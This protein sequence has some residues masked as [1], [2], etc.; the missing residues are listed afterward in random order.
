MIHRWGEKKQELAKCMVQLPSRFLL[1]TCFREGMYNSFKQSFRFLSRG[2]SDVPL[3]KRK[4]PMNQ[5]TW[6]QFTHP[7]MEHSGS[8][9]DQGFLALAIESPDLEKHP[10]MKHPTPQVYINSNLQINLSRKK[11]SS[12]PKKKRRLLS[13]AQ[14]S[15]HRFSYLQGF[16]FFPYHW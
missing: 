8:R 2:K 5:E 1:V 11:N 4:N 16:H 15:S 6:F 13:T 3:F 14:V 12:L 9:E 7:R 10:E